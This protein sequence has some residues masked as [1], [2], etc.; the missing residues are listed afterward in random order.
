MYKL[1]RRRSNMRL[2]LVAGI[3]PT[4]RGLALA[5]DAGVPTSTLGM[6]AVLAQPGIRLVF[7][8]TSAVSARRHAGLAAQAGVTMVDLTPAAVGPFVVPPV[9]LTDHAGA[10]NVNMVSCAGQAAI[11]LVRAVARAARVT[12][13]ELVS[14]VASDSAGPGTRQNIDEFTYTTADAMRQLGGVP[15][16]R[17]IPVLNPAR[18]QIAMTNTVY[19]VVE[20][21]L[22]LAA[23]TSSVD[24]MIAEVQRYVPGYRHRAAPF[25]ERRSTPWGSL[26]TVVVLNQVEGNGDFL[27]RYAGNLDIM[28]AAAWHAGDFF[29]QAISGRA[30]VVG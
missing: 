30:T 26:P 3:D 10:V 25:V 5:R 9:N 20:G 8:A 18:P 2:E 21:D 7:D 4:S 17:A 19:A 15:R 1:L 14:A 29:A 11:P 16:A 6:E 24:A 28:T 27:P 23:V 12:Y 22:D 13:A